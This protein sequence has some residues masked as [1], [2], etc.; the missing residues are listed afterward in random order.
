[1]WRE[2]LSPLSYRQVQSVRCLSSNIIPEID[3]QV[4]FMSDGGSAFNI[5]LSC[6]DH[7]KQMQW[8][9]TAHVSSSSLLKGRAMDE[10]NQKSSFKRDKGSQEIIP[11]SPG[12]GAKNWL[13]FHMG[14]PCRDT[15]TDCQMSGRE[16]EIKAVVDI[17]I[18]ARV[19]GSQHHWLCSCPMMKRQKQL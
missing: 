5:A 9:L 13:A 3:K 1:M 8:R 7:T 19:K 11:V 15:S 12:E 6:L 4:C 18:W 2:D 14:N 10:I 16:S 17:S